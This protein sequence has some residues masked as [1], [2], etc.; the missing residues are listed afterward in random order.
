M[1]QI[2]AIYSGEVSTKYEISLT[3][4]CDPYHYFSLPR[5]NLEQE[6]EGTLPLPDSWIDVEKNLI[7]KN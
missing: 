5:E 4:S 1:I 3:D 2:K 6:R 7:T